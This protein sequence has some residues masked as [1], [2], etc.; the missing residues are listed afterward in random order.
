MQ[1][2]V[3]FQLTGI[4]NLKR[5]PIKVMDFE[6]SCPDMLKPDCITDTHT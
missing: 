3:F 2:R 1:E 5:E 6:R 4:Q